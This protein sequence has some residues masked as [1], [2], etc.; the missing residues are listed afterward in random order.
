MV[1]DAPSGP[2]LVFGSRWL[3]MHVVPQIRPPARL[4]MQQAQQLWL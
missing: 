3:L 1:L 4:L 2:L